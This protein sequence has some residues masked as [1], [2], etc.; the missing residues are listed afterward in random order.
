MSKLFA[1]SFSFVLLLQ[2]FG[3]HFNDLVQIDEFIEHA[4][5]HSEQYGDNVIVFISKHYGELK[6]AHEQEHQE[7]QEDHEQLP[8]QHHCQLTSLVVF[9]VNAIASTIKSPVNLEL[10]T[11]NFHYQAPSSSLHTRGILQPPR[12]S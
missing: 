5:F 9:N 6:A 4:Q 1:I 11:T 2:S 8:F 12:Q 3:L 10:S 7:E